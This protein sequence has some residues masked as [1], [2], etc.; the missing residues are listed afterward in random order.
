M[1]FSLS[2]LLICTFLSCK[3]SKN[4]IDLYE[5]E[6]S[7]AFN[8]MTEYNGENPDTTGLKAVKIYS[9]DLL[10]N[11]QIKDSSLMDYQN[12][13]YFLTLKH[14]TTY[15]IKYDSL[16]RDFERYA[17]RLS[18]NETHFNYRK[19]YDKNSNVKE[20]IVYNKDGQVNFKVFYDYDTE[21]KLIREAK[22]YGYFL[23]DKP[24]LRYLNYFEYPEKGTEKR[25]YCDK[26]VEKIDCDRIAFYKYDSKKRT[27]ERNYGNVENGEFKS[28]EKWKYYYNQDKKVKEEFYELDSLNFTRTLE[29]NKNGLLQVHRIIFPD[30]KRQVSMLKYYYEKER[31][32]TH[33]N[34]YN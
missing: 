31:K 27:I 19:I 4:S 33:N 15:E 20:W 17:T 26:E 11:G 28:R 32:T 14:H 24:I 22:Y 13:D 6:P 16:N 34:V 8:Y 12:L 25:I 3:S 1:K 18:T 2:I 23:Y 7:L 21:N 5:F 30:K 10:K 29:Y 9:Y